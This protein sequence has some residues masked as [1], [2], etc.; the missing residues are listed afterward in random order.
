[1]YIFGGMG[2]ATANSPFAMIERSGWALMRLKDQKIVY[3]EYTDDGKLAFNRLYMDKSGILKNTYSTP[4]D[5]EHYDLHIYFDEDNN[6]IFKKL[7]KQSEWDNSKLDRERFIK[8]RKEYVLKFNFQQISI[9]S[10]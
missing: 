10:K 2:L 8:N 6:L 5:Q 1:M 7:W 9:N 4:S 3:Q